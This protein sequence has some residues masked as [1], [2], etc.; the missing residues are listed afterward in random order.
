MPIKLKT[1]ESGAVAVKKD[2][3]RAGTVEE[4]I[5]HALVKGIVDYIEAGCGRSP[6]E[7]SAAD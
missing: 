2:A 5:K 3:W 6:S 7:I 1:S 4:R